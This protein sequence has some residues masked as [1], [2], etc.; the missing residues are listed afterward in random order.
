MYTSTIETASYDL[1]L[2][3]LC[4]TRWYARYEALNAVYLSFSALV[5]C[6]MK[7]EEDGDAKSQYEAKGLLNKLLSFEFVVLLI[8]SRQVMASTNATT[9]QLQKEDLDILSA[10]DMLTSLLIL[11]QNLRN[12]DNSLMNIFA[13]TVI[14]IY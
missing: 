4:Q 11:L 2:K 6:L 8:F 9:T 10:V 12:D 3:D 5:Q 13:V 7:L 14:F 1:L